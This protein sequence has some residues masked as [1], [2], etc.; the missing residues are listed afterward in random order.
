MNLNGIVSKT[1]GLG[2]PLGPNMLMIECKPYLLSVPG[3]RKIIIDYT[4]STPHDAPE[5]SGTPAVVYND[6]SKTVSYYP[7]TV[8]FY[9]KTEGFPQGVTASFYNNGNS[10]IVSVSQD[11]QEVE[12]GIR[13]FFNSCSGGWTGG[14]FVPYFK[15]YNPVECFNLRMNNS[16]TYLNYHQ[17][18]DTYHSTEGGIHLNDPRTITLR[19]EPKR[20]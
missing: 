6:V 9:L 10:N 1:L 3:S 16:E 18:S 4:F 5:F 11:G 17:S 12:V 7:K 13:D 2:N 15:V 19:Y 8:K 20:C 14:D